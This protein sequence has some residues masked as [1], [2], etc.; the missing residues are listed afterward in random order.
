MKRGSRAKRTKRQGFKSPKT[1]KQYLSLSLKDR[2]IWDSIGHIV[3]RMK[4]GMSL[5]K[6]AREF[7]LSRKVVL[8]RG[9][10]AL[11]KRRTGRY[12]AKKTD[13]LLRVVTVLTRDGKKRVATRDSRQASLIG[14]H[15]AAVQR[16][17]QT[18][19]SSLLAKFIKKR[20][21]DARGKRH[22]FL[23][24]LEELDRQ[25]SAGV[26]SFES[27]YAGNSR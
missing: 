17:L 19:D 5:S 9:R 1:E 3:T 4:S 7:G 26:L 18:G 27:L 24:S 15:W 2:E 10:S 21:V 6:T 25:A 23:I 13:H 11:R 8:A 12:Y 14:S 20:V 16:F 22:S